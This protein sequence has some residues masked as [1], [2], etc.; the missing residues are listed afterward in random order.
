[1][2]RRNIR[3][4]IA[5]RSRKALRRIRIHR[6]SYFSKVYENLC[7]DRWA[8]FSIVIILVYVGVAILTKLG[9]IGVGYDL[10]VAAEFTPPFLFTHFRHR[11]SRPRCFCACFT[12]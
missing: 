12:R 1:M 3:K 10:E 6:Q 8:K 5:L 4:K 11:L 7:R 2:S 9:L